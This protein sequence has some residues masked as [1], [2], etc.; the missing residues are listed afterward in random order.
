M[1][2][3]D[4]YDAINE[5]AADLANSML[6]SESRLPWMQNA[7]QFFRPVKGTS[8]YRFALD[9]VPKDLSDHVKT[10]QLRGEPRS[11]D[12]VVEVLKD[13]ARKAVKE[14]VLQTYTGDTN[15]FAGIMVTEM[16]RG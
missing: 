6:T 7:G 15:I 14:A 5:Y 4:A 11:E 1:N 16:R 10:A 2:L 9:Y 12:Q 13:I 8:N 3:Q